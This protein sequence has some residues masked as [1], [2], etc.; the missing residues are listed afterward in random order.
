MATQKITMNG[1]TMYRDGL[2]ERPMRDKPNTKK[3]GIDNKACWEG[4]RYAGTV[5][6]KDRCVKVRK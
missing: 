1:K 6:G 4:Y 2:D 3:K 5:D